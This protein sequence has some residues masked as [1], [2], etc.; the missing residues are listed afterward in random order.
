MNF[1]DCGNFIHG[2]RLG[3]P[4]KGEPVFLH[5]EAEVSSI[6]LEFSSNSSNNSNL[7][8]SISIEIASQLLRTANRPT[9]IGG[10]TTQLSAIPKFTHFQGQLQVSALVQD[11]IKG[12]I[13]VQTMRADGKIIEDTI[14]QLP[15]SSTLEKSYSTIVPSESDK[16]LRLVLNMAMQD[17]YSMDKNHDFQLPAVLDRQK[18]SIPTAIY[19][20]QHRLE[21]NQRDKKRFI[22]H[23]LS[24]PSGGTTRHKKRRQESL[25]TVV[26][27]LL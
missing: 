27:S 1:S 8:S 14:T 26:N 11:N 6:P 9:T 10:S 4:R 3:Y 20:P 13:K 12:S 19:T 15:Q 23:S 7:T 25:D 16:T 21:S 18:E 2:V 24:D 5:L 22:K 17:T